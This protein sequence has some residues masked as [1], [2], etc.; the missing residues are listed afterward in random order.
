MAKSSKRKLSFAKKSSLVAAA[1]A[2]AT[3]FG[4][5]KAYS[6]GAFPDMSE[7]SSRQEAATHKSSY[8]NLATAGALV[9]GAIGTLYMMFKYNS[10][11]EKLEPAG[12]KN[13]EFFGRDI[14]VD[15]LEMPDAFGRGRIGLNSL[16]KEPGYIQE[17]LRQGYDKNLKPT[18][19][20][21]T[22]FFGR[23]IEV[24]LLEMPDAFG[25]GRIGLNSLLKQPGYVEEALRQGY[26]KNP[27]FAAALKATKQP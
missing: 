8:G 19:K 25:R 10:Q 21:N 17:A 7:T 3:G 23:D 16:L 13:A 22:E 27:E 2:A 18:G 20:K 14:E 6:K 24:D 12:K 5:G 9:T 4:D 15:L 11:D 1:L 26:G